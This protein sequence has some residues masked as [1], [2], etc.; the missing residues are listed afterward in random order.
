[1]EMRHLRPGM[2]EFQARKGEPIEDPHNPQL[3]ELA[4]SNDLRDIYQ[5]ISALSGADPL[6]AICLSGGGIRSATFNLG[7]IQGLARL[8]LLDRFDYLSS[9]SG[10]GFIGGWLKA[11]IR[12]DGTARVVNELDGRTPPEHPLK[13]EP[14][15]V[16]RLREYSNYLTPRRGLLSG[17]TGAVAAIVLRNLLLNWL[18]VVPVFMA[19]IALPQIYYLSIQ[20]GLG[21]SAAPWILG[22]SIGLGLATSIA[23]HRFR[24]PKYERKGGTPI[25]LGVVLPFVAAASLLSLGAA[26]LN[27]S[28]QFSWSL[29]IFAFLWCILIPLAGWALREPFW[30]LEHGQHFPLR[31]LLAMIGSGAVATVV[32]LL[33]AL[34]AYPF[35]EDRPILYALLSVPLLIGIYLLA[36]AL[37]VSMAETRLPKGGSAPPLAGAHED[38]D[39]EWWAR[40]SGYLL[41]IALSWIVLMGITLLGWHYVHR[42]LGSYAMEAMSGAGILSG[43]VAVLLGKSGQTGSGREGGGKKS[44]APMKTLSLATAAPLFC[45]VVVLVLA[46]LNALLARALTGNATLL[47]VP[48]SLQ[49]HETATVAGSD[50]TLFLLLAA[51]LLGF[52]FLMGRA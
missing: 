26:W 12:R 38:L 14:R 40:L 9:V 29:I 42:Y 51:V 36:R 8:G 45:A 37:F 17:D 4:R 48:D 16:D 28:G 11:W 7:V 47:D 19:A 32:F 50:L 35:L 20:L 30:T 13:P 39:R 33:F 43:L 27:W 5:H 18:V 15:P 24:R 21:P 2:R 41:L 25:L 22:L 31:E 46:Q 34:N 44:A 23:T 10:G 1:D 49:R 3:N 6:A 52:G